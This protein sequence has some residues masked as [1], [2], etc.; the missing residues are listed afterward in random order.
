ME[1]T[2]R[3]VSAEE[4]M[5]VVRLALQPVFDVL[6]QIAKLRG[7]L[8]AIFR[9]VLAICGGKV[10]TLDAL[11][12]LVVERESPRPLFDRRRP[13]PSAIRPEGVWCGR[14]ILKRHAW[15]WMPRQM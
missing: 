15:G 14:L 11:L 7:R 3:D 5:E 2:K 10:R 13:P 8:V 12:A 4:V 9:K 1:A 6:R